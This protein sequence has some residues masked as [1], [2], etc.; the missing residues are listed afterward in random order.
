M[1][2]IA[3]ER[4]AGKTQAAHRYPLEP[5][6]GRLSFLAH[7]LHGVE[8]IADMRLPPCGFIS[9]NN[10]HSRTK[11]NPRRFP[12]RGSVRASVRRTGLPVALSAEQQ[13]HSVLILELV[14]GSRL[15]NSGLCR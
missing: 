14:D 4:G 7:R 11:Q 9:F 3:S 5:V 8:L 1:R 6:C 12:A 15:T 10:R 2:L 13:G